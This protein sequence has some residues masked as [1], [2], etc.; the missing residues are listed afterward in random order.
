MLQLPVILTN[1]VS[2][3]DGKRLTAPKS[4]STLVGKPFAVLESFSLK[5]QELGN[6]I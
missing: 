2:L 6:I 3:G 5:D 1:G 4:S